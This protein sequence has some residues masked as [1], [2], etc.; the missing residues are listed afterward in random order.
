MGLNLGKPAPVETPED[1]VYE[2]S[3]PDTPMTRKFG[4]LRGAKVKTVS[5][6][7][8]DFYKYVSWVGCFTAC[9]LREG[10]G[11][12][13]SAPVM[14]LRRVEW[15]PQGMN[16]L[17]SHCGRS[18]SSYTKY[19][20]VFELS[21]CCCFSAT[22]STYGFRGKNRNWYVPCSQGAAVAMLNPILLASF[23]TCCCLSLVRPSARLVFQYKRVVLTQFRT[24]VT[25][26]LQSTHLTVYDARF[27]YDPLFGAG[28]YTSFMR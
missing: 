28:F 12:L 5:E 13:W 26:Y 18:S 16:P 9:F 4:H 22:S 15:H 27:K 1:Y 2:Q 8:E 23:V 17:G 10:P 19:L 20:K 25:E 24:I 7:V 6:T 11:L 14:V 21:S 3:I